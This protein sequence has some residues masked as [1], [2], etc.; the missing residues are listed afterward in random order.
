MSCIAEEL[1]LGDFDFVHSV[2]HAFVSS[3]IP[4][5]VLSIDLSFSVWLRLPDPVRLSTE[6]TVSVMSGMIK[7][8]SGPLRTGG[9]PTSGQTHIALCLLSN[10]ILSI[11]SSRWRWH[12][13]IDDASF[14][15]S[16]L[17]V[18]RPSVWV[19]SP[20]P[21]RVLLIPSHHQHPLAAVAAAACLSPAIIVADLAS[22]AVRATA[23]LSGE[24]SQS[25]VS[26]WD[27]RWD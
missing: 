20:P 22:V 8:P 9:R 15:S 14:S 1:L 4:A 6:S 27:S 19:P 17:L 23:C 2:S 7:K 25:L 10:C 3:F 13:R 5:F 11:I 26:R 24:L 16:K 12:R 18:M 21:F